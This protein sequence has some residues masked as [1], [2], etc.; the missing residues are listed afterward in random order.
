[1][2]GMNVY[3]AKTQTISEDPAV[4][5]VFRRDE[6]LVLEVPPV[7]DSHVKQ[8][9]IWTLLAGENTSLTKWLQWK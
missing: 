4:C 5:H 3:F 9:L 7:S 8:P 1:M 2:L 6:L